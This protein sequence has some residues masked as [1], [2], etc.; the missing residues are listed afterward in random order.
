MNA[1]TERTIKTNVKKA[2]VYL[3]GAQLSS[4]ETVTLPA[5][6][7]KLV[8]EGVSPHLQEASLQASGKG[9]FVIL[10]TQYMLKYKEQVATKLDGKYNRQISMIDDSLEENI[11]KKTDAENRYNTLE[12]EKKMLLGNKTIKG[13]SQKDSL[14]LLKD[15]LDF[16]RDRLN[17][18]MAAELKI[19]RELKRIQKAR[20]N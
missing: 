12:L 17:N 15:G 8:F 5:G 18:I 3:Q 10:E 13:E 6:N 2:I 7:S 4:I 20:P 14:P 11:Y 16:L 19:S 1:Q 9:S